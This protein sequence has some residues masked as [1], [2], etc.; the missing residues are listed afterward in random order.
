MVATLD[1]TKRSAIAIKLADMKAIQQLIIENEQQ[2]LRQIS[3]S[4]IA[5]RIRKMLDD[6][7]KNMGVLETVIGQYGIQAEP[8]KT[9]TQ[10]V[11]KVRQL[12]QSSE[13]S[14]YEK[15]FQHELL[16]HQQVMSGLTI[17]KGKSQ[18]K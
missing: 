14:L 7:N 8:E 4:D 17:H 16:K 10:M 11:E 18:V 1:D 2:L 9:V 12:Q 5:D 13:L 15:V 6:D 3:D